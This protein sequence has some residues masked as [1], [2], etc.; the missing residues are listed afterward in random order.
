MLEESMKAF[1]M[2]CA[3]LM[4]GVA[5]EVQVEVSLGFEPRG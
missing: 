1:G 3:M 4:D 2:G 5:G